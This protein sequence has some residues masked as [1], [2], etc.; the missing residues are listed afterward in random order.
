MSSCLRGLDAICIGAASALQRSIDA[1]AAWANAAAHVDLVEFQKD[2][3]KKGAARVLAQSAADAAR[4][5]ASSLS[6]D[7][8]AKRLAAINSALNK[9]AQDAL[10]NKK[11][12]RWPTSM[13]NAWQTVATGAREA[14]SKS[15]ISEAAVT[16][17][18]AP[19]V[20]DAVKKSR[21]SS[22]PW[23]ATTIGGLALG[24]VAGALLWRSHRG[25]GSLIGGALLGSVAG[26]G[27]YFATRR[28]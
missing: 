20:A 14:S 15:A 11:S 9:A 25:V 16:V 24:G 21:P 27:T 2:D 3:A 1:D 10:D 17:P 6:T 8:Q 4:S 26:T 12:D 23:I 18:V 13:L 5:A 19:I 7:Q 22:L 28:K